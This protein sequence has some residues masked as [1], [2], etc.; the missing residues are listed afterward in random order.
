VQ[1][2]V[3]VARSGV[4]AVRGQVSEFSRGIVEETAVPGFASKTDALVSGLPAKYAESVENLRKF[5]QDLAGAPN[6]GLATISA[7][8]IDRTIANLTSALQDSGYS[9][10]KIADIMSEFKESTGDILAAQEKSRTFAKSGSPMLAKYYEGQV[11]KAVERSLSKLDKVDDIVKDVSNVIENVPLTTRAQRAGQ[12]LVQKL[13]AKGKAFVEGTLDNMSYKQILAAA[14]ETGDPE[15][16]AAVKKGAKAAGLSKGTIAQRLTGAVLGSSGGGTKTN[17]YRGLKLSNDIDATLSTLGGS[18]D[19]PVG[20]IEQ[21]TLGKWMSKAKNMVDPRTW[22]GGKAGIVS[23]GASAAMDIGRGLRYGENL[24]PIGRGVRALGTGIGRAVKV[25]SPI[26]DPISSLLSVGAKGAEKIG[27]KTISKGLAKAIPGIGW[28]SLLGDVFRGIDS[29]WANEHLWKKIFNGKTISEAIWSSGIAKMFQKFFGD[30]A[31]QHIRKALT[32]AF[33]A[34]KDLSKLTEEAFGTAIGLIKGLFTGDW[35]SF[36]EHLS[37]MKDS[38]VSIFKNLGGWLWELVMAGW[39]F[40]KKILGAISGAFGGAWDWIKSDEGVAGWPSKIW[41]FLSGIGKTL[42]R[43]WEEVKGWFKDLF[44]GAWDWISGK[45]G[46]AGWPDKIWGFINSIPSK[47]NGLKDALTAVGTNIVDWIATGLKDAASLIEDIPIFGKLV[48]LGAKGVELLTDLA[49]SALEKIKR[50]GDIGP[51]A[52]DILPGKLTGYGGMQQN[53]ETA[54]KKLD[55]AYPQAEFWGGY[56]RKY[57]TSKSD[58][59]V[60][61]AFDVHS[62]VKS[63]DTMADWLMNNFKSLNLKYVIWQQQIN[64][65]SGWRNMKDRGSATA[66]H[67]DHIHVSTYHTG[68]LVEKTK[69]KLNEVPAIL[70][71]GERVLS[72]KDTLW[73]DELK[74]LLSRQK[75][76]TTVAAPSISYTGD[77]DN[78]TK[79]SVI[80]EKGAIGEIKDEKDIHKTVDALEKILLEVLHDTRRPK[81]PTTVTRRL[82]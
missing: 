4:N 41:G 75:Q 19:A 44:K 16:I 12:K 48:K 26:L 17:M 72:K 52:D 28:A 74:T 13:P 55:K 25:A 78:S 70:Q 54:W 38:F 76:D 47:I 9:P 68:G 18:I 49:G 69:L 8:K 60:G 7:N 11:P 64:S 10:E 2:G 45:D 5:T 34:F 71:V 77:T 32:H 79:I 33:D 3:N 24:T 57:H 63:M 6:K 1:K 66:N 56:D 36:K 46:I 42:S 35:D 73:M 62:S 22:V 29:N 67:M 20:R 31:F 53:A 21:R 43:K 51:L 80:F 81:G 59:W 30:D 50:G 27:M 23:P 40:D 15:V 37:G 65:G 14:E 82:R 61:K 39:D 58:H